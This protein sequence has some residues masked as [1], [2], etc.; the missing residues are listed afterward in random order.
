MCATGREHTWGSTGQPVMRKF[1]DDIGIGIGSIR[2]YF[3]SGEPFEGI[4]IAP[5]VK[6]AGTRE[7]HYSKRDAAL[8]KA[9]ELASS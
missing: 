6:A 8:E 3:P 2:S 9:I 7:D 4:G 5:D 1:G